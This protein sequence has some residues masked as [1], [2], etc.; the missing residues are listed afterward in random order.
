LETFDPDNIRDYTDALLKA[1]LQAEEEG[2]SCKEHL[3]ENA[4]MMAG[5][6]T[7]FLAGSETTS[8]T[9]G[10]AIIYLL[11]N[12]IVQEK[13]HKEIDGVIGRDEVP[14]LKSKKD[15][16]LLEAFTAETLRMS[17]L[18]PLCVL[19]KTTVDTSFM[20]YQIPKGTLIVPNLWSLHHDSAFWKEPFKFSPERFLDDEGRFVNPPGGTLLPFGA[21][22]RTCMGEVLARSELYLFLSRLLQKFKFENPPGADLPSL[23]GDRGVVMHPKPYT[24]CVKK[25]D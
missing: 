25:R 3:T 16:P 8:T 12:P 19:H 20:G 9:L 7:L 1:K 10:W 11:H 2:K 23:E 4:L 5:P 15:L 17:S 18:L 14:T 21:G 24:V 22:P 13:L 6:A